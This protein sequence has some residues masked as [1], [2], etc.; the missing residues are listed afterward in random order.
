MELCA[1]GSAD[2]AHLDDGPYEAGGEKEQ[3]PR[4]IPV[5]ANSYLG[6]D[7][8]WPRASLTLCSSLLSPP[9]HAP[10]LPSLSPS[11]SLSLCLC[12]Y[13]FGL[14]VSLMLSPPFPL[15]LLALCLALFLPSVARL[16]DVPSP[17]SLPA[18][19]PRP[20]QGCSL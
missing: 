2:L 6:R 7:P 8:S 13:P 17:V 3:D 18:P 10:T 9:L 14:F 4:L 12:S 20:P 1:Q 11:L 5:P 15:L 19:P 16:L